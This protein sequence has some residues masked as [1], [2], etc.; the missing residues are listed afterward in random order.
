MSFFEFY[1]KNE[2]RCRIESERTTM[3]HKSIAVTLLTVLLHLS[4]AQSTVYLNLNE[5]ANYPAIIKIARGFPA[6]IEFEENVAISKD[7]P[8]F[9]HLT[10]ENKVV[11]SAK[12][13]TGE[14]GMFATLRNETAQFKVVIDNDITTSMRYIVRSPRVAQPKVIDTSGVL[15]EG[16]YLE[17]PRSVTHPGASN[18]AAPSITGADTPPPSGT[19]PSNDNRTVDPVL[20]EPGK[21]VVTTANDESLPFVFEAV[22]MTFNGQRAINYGIRN[23]SEKMLYNDIK[24]LTVTVDGVRNNY[25]TL[26]NDASGFLNRLDPDSE[27]RGMILLVD[28][29]GGPITLTWEIV[30]TP[31]NLT[32]TIQETLEE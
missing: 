30:E 23:R 19:T 29:H 17:L 26:R 5:I 16:A 24:R 28:D 31:A 8:L 32:Y 2:S 7:S 12:S 18:S 3:T 13:S 14:G 10:Q 4:Q 25:E 9:E 11:V 6:I 20:L 15:L 27:E 1:D 22:L 21:Q